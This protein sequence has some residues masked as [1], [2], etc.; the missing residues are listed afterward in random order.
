MSE[1]ENAKRIAALEAKVAELAQQCLCSYRNGIAFAQSCAA[2]AF[3]E[4]RA[5][6]DRQMMAITGGVPY[7]EYAAKLAGETNRLLGE[8]ARALKV[9]LTDLSGE[10]V[11]KAQD[12][13]W[14]K[15]ENAMYGTDAY[16]RD[17][18]TLV[19]DLRANGSFWLRVHHPDKKTPLESYACLDEAMLGQRIAEWLA[20]H[21]AEVS[22]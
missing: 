9:S 18:L 17:G 2:E 13:F 14:D 10:T 8:V 22:L 7:D 16:P 11:A 6:A 5:A 19:V 4:Q 15:P 3:A 12:A 21:P 20:R 1:T